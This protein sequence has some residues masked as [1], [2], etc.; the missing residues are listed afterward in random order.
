MP[1]WSAAEHNFKVVVTVFRLAWIFARLQVPA[2][3]GRTGEGTRVGGH[4]GQ[5]AQLGRDRP[6]EAEFPATR[7]K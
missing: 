6:Q 3:L 1:I 5:L 4:Q 7:K 2:P